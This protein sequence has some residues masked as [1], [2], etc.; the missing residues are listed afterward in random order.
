MKLE[1]NKKKNI[2]TEYFGKGSWNG[3]Q[4]IFCRQDVKFVFLVERHSWAYWLLRYR[5]GLLLY[6]IKNNISESESKQINS[7]FTSSPTYLFYIQYIRNIEDFKRKYQ[8]FLMQ[9][10]YMALKL[11]YI[12]SSFFITPKKNYF[13]DPSLLRIGE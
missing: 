6:F 1:E 9:E 7:F 13:A 10:C 3:S 11:F 5:G 4:V 8:F 2:I 12:F